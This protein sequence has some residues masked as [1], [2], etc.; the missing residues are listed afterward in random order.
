MSAT[1]ES[2]VTAYA[3]NELEGEELAQVELLLQRD[4]AV[5]A[6][7]EAIQSFSG[8]LAA[9]LAHEA[10]AEPRPEAASSTFIQWTLPLAAA[11]ALG[12]GINAWFLR[13]APSVR[14]EPVVASVA[15]SSGPRVT[16]TQPEKSRTRGPLTVFGE[17]VDAHLFDPQPAPVVTIRVPKVTLAD[18]WVPNLGGPSVGVLSSNVILAAVEPAPARATLMLSNQSPGRLPPAHYPSDLVLNGDLQ[19]ILNIPPPSTDLRLNF[20]YRSPVPRPGAPMRSFIA[21]PQF[22]RSAAWLHGTD[23]QLPGLVPTMDFERGIL[24]WAEPARWGQRAPPQMP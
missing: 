6:E 24:I 20:S 22:D 12:L 10:I 18:S 16:L 5:R 19:Q 23:A 17:R 2:L 21:D 8:A 1:E 3:L 9:A 13:T 4:P 7:V 11:V 14:H 15:S